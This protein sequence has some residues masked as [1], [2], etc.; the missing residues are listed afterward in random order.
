MKKLINNI[1]R[2]SVFLLLLLSVTSGVQGRDIYG[3]MVGNANPADIPI[4]MYKFDSKTLKTTLIS[5]IMASFWGGAYANG[6]YYLLLSSDYQGNMPEGL[7]F[8]DLKTG[9]MDWVDP[10]AFY[11]CSDLTFDRTSGIMYGVQIQN[12]GGPI[13]HT[14]IQINLEDGTSTE[15]AEL[16][17]KIGAIAC[18]YWGDMYGMGYDGNL[19]YIDKTNGDLTQVATTDFITNSEVGQSMEFDHETGEL[20]WSFLDTDDKAHFATLDIYADSIVRD[21]RLMT[22]NALILG[23]YAEVP[24]ADVHVPGAPQ[25]L[26]IN[27]KG[28]SV[29]LSWTNPMKTL[30][31]NALTAISKIEVYKNNRLVYTDE[32]V[33]P[34]SQMS[35]TDSSKE[36]SGIFARYT[37]FA[38]NE[39][40][41]G[42]G[43]SDKILTGEDIPGEVTNLKAVAEGKNAVLTWTAPEKGKK[44]GEINPD[45]LV[46]RITRLP[47]NKLFEGI[48]ECT[49]TDST[50]TVCA[51]YRYKVECGNNQGFSNAVESEAVVVGNPIEPPFTTDFSSEL[52]AAQWL[53]ADNNGDNTTWKWNNNSYEYS[54]SFFNS[55]DD[56]LISV[57]FHLLKG[58]EYKVKYT[59]S[60]PSMYSTPE[61]FKLSLGN[62]VLEE[63]E[64]FNNEAAEERSVSFTVEEDGNYSF[65]LSA[66]SPK[67]NW[68]IIISSFAVDMIVNYDM[69]VTGMEGEELLVAGKP[70]TYNVTV[71]NKGLKDVCAGE[72]KLT[73]EEGNILASAAVTDT[74]PVDSLYVLPLE[75]IPNVGVQKVTATSYLEN[76]FTGANDTFSKEVFVINENEY[77]IETGNDGSHPSLMPFAFEGTSYTFAQTIYRQEDLNISK[78]LIKGIY[79]RYNNASKTLTKKHI[80]VYLADSQSES[81]LDGWVDAKD[82]TLVF[83]GEVDF[84]YGDNMLYL[85]LET[86]FTY[87]GPNLRVLTEKLNDSSFANIH[88]NAK[89]CD[90][91][92][93]TAIYAG[94]KYLV[95][96]DKVQGSSMLNEIILCVEDLKS[97]IDSVEGE[98]EIHIFCNEG[99]LNVDRVAD[100]IEIYNVSGVL[101]CKVTD[102]DRADVSML[103]G[104]AYIVRVKCG[105]AVVVKKLFVK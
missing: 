81:M 55:A 87:N 3:F 64:S 34:G 30:E 91:E 31:G 43:A 25:N 74:I 36:T 27:S 68:K 99:I 44:G 9:N 104:G 66:L 33:Q 47:D 78:G 82:M 26:T 103:T 105:K 7:Q 46:Y 60:A 96:N 67:D 45:E 90:P 80:K 39:S 59:I 69:A 100:C 19:Y 95:E 32:N 38:Y 14:L 10:Y 35:W 97:G 73:D 37:V 88:F 89:N 40:G 65:K 86:P 21:N 16:S 5:G 101:I 22:D 49:F 4:G 12:A 51:Y 42:E 52:L 50:T 57:P 20:Y 18:S 2:K 8:F 24:P 77:F 62:R 48:K 85:A 54:F 93:R 23:L 94:E 17:V 41:R 102:T 75:W 83:D 53:V 61:H 58:M 15:V 70:V 72:V 11:Q 56:D 28:G 13:A 1:L 98:D 71:Q 6:Y 29:E 84:K 76:D 79:Y 63:L 92:V